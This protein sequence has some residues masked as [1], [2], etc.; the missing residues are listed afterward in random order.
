MSR[1]FELLHLV[2]L[3]D[4]LHLD[5]YPFYCKY[6]NKLNDLHIIH[7]S[8]LYDIRDLVKQEIELTI[9]N[10]GFFI[11][12]DDSCYP[13]LLRNINSP[14]IVL[15]AKGNP[16]IFSD[17][18]FSFVSVV[19]SRNP[20]Q[21]AVKLTKIISKSIVNQNL[22]IVSGFA[23]GVDSIAHKVSVKI[24][25]VCFFANGINVCYPNKNLHLLEEVIANNG[26]VLTEFPF[27]KNPLA[28]NFYK[29]NRLIAG[30]SVATV[31]IECSI[32]SGTMITARFANQ[33]NREIYSVPASPFQ[34]RSSGNNFLI[35][36]NMAQIITNPFLVGQ[37]IKTEIIDNYAV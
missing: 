2:R 17:F 12:I 33:F 4:T 13:Y 23:R 35:A 3:C 19:G 7:N 26:L 18:P 29:R 10:G 25:T 15:I 1:L 36:N 6:K 21:N 9:S 20:T 28:Q 34:E 22:K 5:P 32:K 16:D 37:T 8:K 31:V 30:S 24:G 27:N 11:T 14:P